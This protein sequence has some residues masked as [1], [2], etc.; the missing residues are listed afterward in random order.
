MATYAE[1]D[2]NDIVINVIVAHEDVIKQAPNPE[3]FIQ[4][5][6]NTVGGKHLLGKEPIRKNYAAI[7]YTYDRVRDAFIPPKL[8]ASFIFNE[9]T[10]QWDPPIPC[11]D[12]PG[13]VYKWNEEK[14]NW[15]EQLIPPEELA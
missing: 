1:I 13:Y 5:S 6:R 8:F 10:C 9:E 15:D 2:E 7:G 4:T 14:T 11:P 3:A 12:K